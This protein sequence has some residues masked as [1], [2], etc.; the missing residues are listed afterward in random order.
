MFVF[1]GQTHLFGF[2]NFISHADLATSNTEYLQDDCL[3][4]GVASIAR[5][6]SVSK[7]TE[8]SEYKKSF[9]VYHSQPFYTHPQGYKFCL[10]IDAN[11]SYE[12]FGIH[13][14]VYATL[15]R[16]E[17]D[18][19]LQWPFTGEFFIEVLNWRE[20]KGHHCMILSIFSDYG[21][22]RIAGQQKY[23]QSRGWPQF[24]SLSSL[25]YNPTTN[26]EYLQDDCLRL[27]VSIINR[28]KY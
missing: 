6:V 28:R 7:L 13:V 17:H 26:T 16:G 2:T 9:E 25:P 3:I 27:R 24:I 19:H 14:S 12:G 4:L 20:D 11:G 23:G 15:M 1:N 18:Q 21:F 5:V 10:Q 8:F 22:V